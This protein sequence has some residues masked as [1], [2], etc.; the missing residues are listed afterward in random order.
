MTAGTLA[1]EL[2][3]HTVDFDQLEN[4]YKPMLNLV[5]ELIGVVPNCDTYLEMWPTGFRTYNLLVP[6]LLNLPASLIGQGAPKDLLGL[7]MY[8]ASMAAGCMY[9]SAHT[10]S[11]AMRR[12]LSPDALAGNYNDAE[13]AVVNL[14]EALGRVP[15]DLSS[16]HL[17][18]LRRYLSEEDIEWLVLGVGLMGFL[19]KFMDGMG[20]E[21]E[22]EAIADVQDVIGDVGWSTGKHQWDADLVVES[23]EEIPQDSILTYLRVFR[24]GPRAARLEGRWTKGVSGRAGEALLLLEDEVGYSFPVLASLHNKK[25]VRAVATVLRDNLDTETTVVGL[26]L[27]CM[28]GVVFAMTVGNE[29]L[30]SEMVQLADLSRSKVEHD[31]LVDLARFGYAS[32][33][34]AEVPTGLSVRENAAIQLARA[35][36]PSPTNVTEIT[37]ESI[38]PHLRPDEI[39]ELMVWLSVLQM[40]HRLYTYYD[41]RIGII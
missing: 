22:P 26:P 31:L 6:N 36:S 39:V 9:C 5:K 41:A 15:S 23:S 29:M 7:A 3:P 33:E 34:K 35:V 24:Q 11:F 10:C 40:L 27:K 8:A 32:N 19:N 12:G 37:V 28:V 21:L 13:Q 14:A 2:A 30:L 1:Q 18:D 16:K 20:I 4:D 17:E 38:T 25:P